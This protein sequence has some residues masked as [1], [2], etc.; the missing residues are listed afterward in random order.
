M[1]SQYVNEEAANQQPSQGMLL[2]VLISET[3]LVLVLL[4]WLLTAVGII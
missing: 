4:Y 1:E 3:T 2:F